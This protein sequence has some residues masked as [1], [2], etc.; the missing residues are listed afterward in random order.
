L[1]VVDGRSILQINHII[2]HITCQYCWRL[3][4]DVICLDG[5]YFVI[6]ATTLFVCVY[7]SR[8]LSHI[9]LQQTHTQILAYGIIVIDCKIVQVQRTNLLLVFFKH[10]CQLPDLSLIEFIFCCQ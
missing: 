9:L 1:Q 6:V 8:S 10:V 3:I 2:D 5:F 7:F 4:I